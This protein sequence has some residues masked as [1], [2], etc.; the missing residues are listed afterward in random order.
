LK[1]KASIRGWWPEKK[2]LKTKGYEWNVYKN[3]YVKAVGRI[4][5]PEPVGGVEAELIPEPI[6]PPV[7]EPTTQPTSK[8]I[9]EGLEEYLPFLR[10]LYENRERLYQ[11]ITGTREDGIIPRYALPGEVGTKAIYM[12]K[13]IAKLAGEF[14]KEKNVA[15]KEVMEGALVEYLMKYGF[16]REVE[17]LLRN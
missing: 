3:N 12:S 2:V 6:S 10:Y 8:D 13:V 5:L 17:T 15:L 9:P 4:D 7:L 1:Q 16:K 14:S 11:L